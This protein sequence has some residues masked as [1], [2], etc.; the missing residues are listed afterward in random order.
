MLSKTLEYAAV[1]VHS[2]MYQKA[3]VC[4]CL[5]RPCV[6]MMFFP[7][8]WDPRHSCLPLFF[9]IIC[10]SRHK[11]LHFSW[12]SASMSTG[13]CIFPDYMKPWDQLSVIFL[14]AQTLNTA[15]CSFPNELH[16]RAQ[17]SW[18]F[19]WV[20]CS[21]VTGVC[22]SQITYVRGHCRL[23]FS[24]LPKPLG[25]AVWFFCLSVLYLPLPWVG[26]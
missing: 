7:I 24:W 23:T 2:A 3:L 9:L 19:W 4:I 6:L 11:G 17:V 14:I 5:V 1:L 20:N 21:I 15:L 25:K 22:T 13:V 16:H 12:L 10:A 8:S 18:F 26:P